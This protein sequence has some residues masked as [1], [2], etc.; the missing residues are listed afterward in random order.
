MTVLTTIIGLMPLMYATGVG[1]DTIV[2]LAADRRLDLRWHL[3]LP[4]FVLKG[5]RVRSTL[6]ATGHD[7]DLGHGG[8]C[9]CYRIMYP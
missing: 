4:I 2:R 3:V 6:W 9:Y 5:W 7:Q 1:A 8:G